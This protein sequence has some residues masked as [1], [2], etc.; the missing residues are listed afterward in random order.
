MYKKK[1]VI[2][3]KFRTLVVVIKNNKQILYISKI[4]IIKK[5][6]RTIKNYK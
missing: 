5:V 3:I 2:K 6:N 4:M 1:I